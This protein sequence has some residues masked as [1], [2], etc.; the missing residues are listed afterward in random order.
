M[1]DAVPVRAAGVVVCISALAAG[2]VVLAGLVCVVTCVG[3]VLT[4]AALALATALWALCPLRRGTRPTEPPSLA[5]PVAA[6]LKP[7][8]TERETRVPAD[9]PW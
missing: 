3:V 9:G 4:L 2:V 8:F 6:S 5:L 1:V 7:E